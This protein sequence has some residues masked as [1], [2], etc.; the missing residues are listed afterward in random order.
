MDI[1]LLRDENWGL[2]LAESFILLPSWILS[3]MKIGGWFHELGWVWLILNIVMWYYII[4]GYY[5][6]TRNLKEDDST[7]WQ[8]VWF[9][10]SWCT[11]RGYYFIQDENW[12]MIPRVK[13]GRQ[14]YSVSFVGI[15]LLRYENWRMIPRVRLAV[16]LILKIVMYHSWILFY[17]RW[18]LE[19]D[20]TN[21]RLAESFILFP[22]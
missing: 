18:K 15:I 10:K 9:L 2:R 1:I 22:S 19:D 16:S 14:F 13:V 11:I 6:L 4:R 20:S 12:R 8:W 17:T 21:L 7:S 3:Y 5:F